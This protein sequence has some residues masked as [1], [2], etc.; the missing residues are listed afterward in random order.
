[1]EEEA[2]EVAWAGNAGVGE[3]I[4]LSK[5]IWREEGPP[6]TREAGPGTPGGTQAT[7]AAETTMVTL[8]ATALEGG[9]TPVRHNGAA[10]R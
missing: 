1:M 5:T 7:W 8:A 3:G 6:A 4:T 2:A 9:G 10:S